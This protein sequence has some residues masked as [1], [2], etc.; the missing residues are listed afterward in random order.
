VNY[1]KVHGL[2]VLQKL[3]DRFGTALIGEAAKETAKALWALIR[4]A[5]KAVW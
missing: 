3:Q 5:V 1:L 2:N 4:E